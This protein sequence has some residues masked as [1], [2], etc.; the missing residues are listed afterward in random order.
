MA[1]IHIGKINKTQVG[2]GKVQLIFHVPVIHPVNGIVPTPEST[3]TGLNQAEIDALA[4]GTLVEL[5]RMMGV[6]SSQSQ[7]EIATAIRAHYAVEFASWN[8]Q[9]D[10]EHKFYG[11][12][13]NAT[14]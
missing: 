9:F 13:L 12:T 1:D 11:V 2:K 7:A 10:F 3:L 8:D 14:A 4:A 6:T 5:A